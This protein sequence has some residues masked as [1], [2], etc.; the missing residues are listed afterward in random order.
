MR[1]LAT[2]VCTTLFTLTAQPARSQT[3]SISP[4]EARVFIDSIRTALSL[5]GLVVIV[6]RSEGSP[7]IIVTGVRKFGTG[8]SIQATDRMHLGSNGKAITATMIGVL[9]EQGRLTFETTLAEALPD[10]ATTMRAEYR[11]AT[12]RQLLGHSAGIRSYTDLR[13]FGSFMRPTGDTAAQRRAFAA[14]LLSEPSLFAPGTQHA[15]SNAG[16]ALAGIVAERITGQPYEKLVDSLVFRPL[17]GHAQF[18]NPGTDAAPQPFGHTRGRG[19]QARI[20]DPRDVEFVVPPVITSAGDASVTLMDYGKF[21]QMHLRG[22]RGI[23][24]VVKATTI[25]ELHTAIAPVDSGTKFGAGWGFA[26]TAD[27]FETHGHT[28]SGGAYIAVAA[29]QPSRDFAI[30]ILTNIGGNDDVLPAMAK[31]RAVITPRLAGP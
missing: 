10:L 21:L 2:A 11:Q 25:R 23:D 16:V 8:D 20:V 13:E 22:M 31:L 14:R 5:P 9:V 15:Y 29:I 7:E 12:V 30:A 17:G 24:G 19:S 6:A 3:L 27:G 1:R 28:G 4:R 26:T 18:G